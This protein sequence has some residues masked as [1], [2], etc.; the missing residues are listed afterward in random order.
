MNN[1]EPGTPLPD[2][3]IIG[4]SAESTSATLEGTSPAVHPFHGVILLLCALFFFACMDTTTKYLS[5]HYNVPLIMAIRYIVH[6]ALMLVLLAPRQGMQLV[7]TQR[8]GLVVVRALCLVAV[9]LFVGLAL[10][11]MP[12]AESTAIFFLAPMLVVLI[13]G[14][15]LRE[16]IGALGWVS[17]IGGFLGV[18]LIAR[19][20][21]GL[22]AAGV[23]FGLMAASANAVY[24]LLSRTLAATERTVTLLFHT[25]LAGSICFG[26][27]LPWFWK[28]EAPTLWQT[29]LFLS[30]GVNGGIGHYL[31]TAAFRHA[32]A[33]S[34]APITYFQL[35]WAL[36]L[37]WMVFGHMPDGLTGI[38]MLAVAASGMAMAL[39]SR[40]A[41][42][43]K[44]TPF[45]GN[46]KT[47]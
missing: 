46:R 21:G 32:P 19:P 8:T 38:G 13:A 24:Q 9:S 45:P 7:R 42:P 17:A 29:I 6:C 40:R 36:V 20:G 39:K 33:S 4:A 31:F 15:M 14:P 27:F 5:V 3:G 2:S 25:A 35:V 28:G 18:L 44:K 34:L 26:L 10:Q 30:M 22:D 47:G 12:V 37:G 11:R 16:R 1:P 41:A 23:A 43:D